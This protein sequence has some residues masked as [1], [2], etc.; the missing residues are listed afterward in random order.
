MKS[1]VIATLL[2]VTSLLAGCNPAPQATSN[3]MQRDQQATINAEG[4]AEV[5]MP[6]IVNFRDMRGMKFWY[7]RRDQADLLTYTYTKNMAGQWVWFCDSIGYPIPGGT[8][9]SAPESMQRYRV[10]D[11]RYDISTLAGWFFGV[12]RLPQPEPNGVFPP[13][14]AEGTGIICINPN[15]NKAGAAYAEDKLNT[16]EWPQPNALNEPNRSGPPKIAPLD[17]LVKH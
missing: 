2:G 7:E 12:A 13:T 10:R 8:Q 15:T 16:F 14:T 5:G 4:A 3:D 1:T 6:H 9:Y 17:P 11:L